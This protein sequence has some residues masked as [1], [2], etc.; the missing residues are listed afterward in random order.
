[1]H[2]ALIAAPPVTATQRA[3]APGR[4]RRD[5][6]GRLRSAEMAAHL[7]QEQRERVVASLLLDAGREKPTHRR[8]A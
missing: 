4:S 3:G 5:I 6:P 7:H 1:M 8:W 2:A